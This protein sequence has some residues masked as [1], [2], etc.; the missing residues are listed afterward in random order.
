M[1]MLQDLNTY[2]ECLY[3]EFVFTFSGVVFFPL[4][5]SRFSMHE[6]AF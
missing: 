4:L 6:Y 2:F 5:V 3:I 1:I